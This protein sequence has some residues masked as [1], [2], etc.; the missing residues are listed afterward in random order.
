MLEPIQLLCEDVKRKALTRLHYEGRPVH[1]PSTVVDLA[2]YA[3]SRYAYY[4]CCK[5]EKAYYGGEVKCEEEVE[6]SED[7]FDPLELICGACS[8]VARAQVGTI[9]VL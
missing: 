8:D 4:M 1:D 5:C 9:Q 7:D 2:E 6:Q 3:M